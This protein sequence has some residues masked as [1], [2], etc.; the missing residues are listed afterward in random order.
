MPCSRVW[1][2]VH[3]VLLSSASGEMRR[4]CNSR[5]T[6]IWYCGPS[7]R[8]VPLKR[9]SGGVHKWKSQQS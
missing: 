7:A 3:H 5:T 6:S 4:H 8:E 2:V 9:G 1:G